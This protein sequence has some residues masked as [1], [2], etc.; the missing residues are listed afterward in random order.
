MKHQTLFI[1]FV[2]AILFFACDNANKEKGEAG[3]KTGSSVPE[4]AMI[5]P[6]VNDTLYPNGRRNLFLVGRREHPGFFVERAI[7]PPGY[8]S[9][10]HTHSGD[11]YTTVITGNIN[12]VRISAADSSVDTKVY[13]PGSFIIIPADQTHF[14]W[15]TERTVLDLTGIGPLNTINAP[16][17]HSPQ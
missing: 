14:E 8:K 3:V 13:G 4:A 16:I 12:L 6:E 9:N 10:P 17:V 5:I 2:T 11:L 1:L 15:F 7:F